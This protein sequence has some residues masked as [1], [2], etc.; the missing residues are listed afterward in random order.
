MEHGIQSMLARSATWLTLQHVDGSPLIQ[1]CGASYLRKPMVCDAREGR[2]RWRRLW[3][4]DSDRW[5]RHLS[6]TRHGYLSGKRRVP[7]RTVFDRAE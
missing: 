4:R 6:G 3:L 5:G 2:C 1:Q 7:S